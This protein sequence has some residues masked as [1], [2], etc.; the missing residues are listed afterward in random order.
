MTVRKESYI[1][2]Q[3]FMVNELE[4]KGNE[5]IVYAL[6]YGF[7][8]DGYSWFSGSQSY[9]TKWLGG[10]SRTTVD[11]CLRKLTKK[12]LLAKRVR[13]E[14]EVRY[15]DYR[16]LVP[17]QKE[18]VQKMDTLPKNCTGDVQNLDRGCTETVQGGC[19]ESGHNKLEL[20]ITRDSNRDMYRGKT[21]FTPPTLEEVEAYI[22]EKGYHVNA[23]KWY[24]HY[25]AN[26]WKVGRNK[27][28][29]WHAAV[30]TWEYSDF[31]EGSNAKKQTQSAYN[32][33]QMIIPPG[34]E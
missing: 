21:R 30:R 2:I 8:Q 23:A 6:I 31:G 28:K 3:A 29:D 25:E 1:T 15:C 32:T 4:L 12:G 13:V 17:E 33:T 26:G 18:D 7:S 20:D 5:L 22:K 11:S 10:A 9:I 16:A 34:W 14:N 24:A 27:M 19:T